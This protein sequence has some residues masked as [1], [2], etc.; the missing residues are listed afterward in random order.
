[1]T[2][3]VALSLSFVVEV[4]TSAPALHR[5]GI[6]GRRKTGVIRRLGYARQECGHSR[7]AREVIHEAGASHSSLPTLGDKAQSSTN[8]SNSPLMLRP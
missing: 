7:T 5:P 6:D 4:A 8:V 2:A 1:M 3:P